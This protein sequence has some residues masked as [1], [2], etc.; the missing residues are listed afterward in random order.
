MYHLYQQH[1]QKLQNKG[2]YRQLPELFGT[3][4][5]D[6]STNDYLG[7]SR[8]KELLDAAIAAG[9]AYGVG[10]TGSRLL[11][12]NQFL[13]EALEM[14]IAVDKGT[15]AALVFNSGFQANISVLSSLLDEGVLKA[16]PLVFFD[17]L[18]HASLYSAVFLSGAELI[19]YNHN[20]IDQ[21]SNLLDKHPDDRPKFIVAETVFG[22]DGD[23]LP[24]QAVVD[25]AEK[26]SAFLYLDEA[27]ATGIF[28][29][30]G[31]GLSTT[32][33][34]KK[35]PHLVMGTFS[36]ALG[37]S[38]AYVACSEILKNYFVNH[39]QGFIYSTA[40]SPMVIGAA[41]KA[42]D[43]VR[44]MDADRSRLLELA[45]TLRSQLQALGCDVGTSASHIIP[46]ILGSE[47]AVMEAKHQLLK[48]GMLVSAIR[49]PTVPPNT[50]RLRIALTTQHTLQDIQR[51]VDALIPLMARQVKS[52]K[53]LQKVL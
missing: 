28:G 13:F 21:L 50:S 1:F 15:E 32:V 24:M 52:P 4:R 36:K 37:V 12:G 16:K 46:V 7:L 31:Y 27:H 6:F 47:D 34:L 8:R 9:R 18:N 20:D 38:G 48:S 3:K 33:S 30:N 51:L 11:S 39:S 14:R 22:M 17:K 5:L 53:P 43:I 10:A 49:P 41:L 42:W 2:K 23:V 26:H 40:N 44:T 25:L 19:R 29:K 45:N 35:V